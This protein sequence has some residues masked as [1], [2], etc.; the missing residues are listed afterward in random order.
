MIYFHHAKEVNQHRT[1][2][3][4][5][6][7]EHCLHSHKRKHSL[8]SLTWSEYYVIKRQDIE[9]VITCNY[10]HG[11][12]VWHRMRERVKH[13][14]CKRRNISQ[15]R[16]HEAME[17]KHMIHDLSQHAHDL[18]MTRR[19]RNHRLA[20]AETAPYIADDEYVAISKTDILNTSL[21]RTKNSTSISCNRNKRIVNQFK[22]QFDDFDHVPLSLVGSDLLIETD[23]SS[24][25]DDD[26]FQMIEMKD[27]QQGKT[28][29]T[30]M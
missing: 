9:E 30:E 15:S 13:S 26:G 7:G 28:I 25:S 1:K 17:G 19:S 3:G 2:R 11:D 4:D 10:K 12:R 27:L 21:T 29:E 22:T 24:H 23:E 8:K 20:K 18:K 16:Q 6:I 14:S 5:V